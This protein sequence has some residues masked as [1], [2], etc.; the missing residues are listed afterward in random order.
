MTETMAA[1]KDDNFLIF[2][3]SEC[4]LCCQHV[5]ANNVE[6]FRAVST[7]PDAWN[8]D[9]CLASWDTVEGLSYLCISRVAASMIWKLGEQPASALLTCHVSISP[10]PTTVAS[11]C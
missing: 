7:L 8:P 10:S 2:F 1:Y 6:T 4:A 3:S 9:P 11:R 5:D